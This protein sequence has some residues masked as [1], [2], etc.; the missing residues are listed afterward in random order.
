MDSIKGKIVLKNKIISGNLIFNKKIIEVSDVKNFNNDNYIIPGYIDLH[1]HGGRGYDTMDGLQ[2]ISKLSR[3]HL[4]NGTTTIFPTTVTASLNDTFNAM[5]GLNKFIKKNK[6]KIN[7]EGV[8]LEGPF[9]NPNKLGAQPPFAQSPNLDFINEI[10]KEAPIKIMTIA[11]EILGGLDFIDT[12]IQYGIKPQL[13]HSLASMD[14]CNLS[15]DRGVESFTH[16]YNAMSGFDH[17]NPG[18][19]ASAFSN[20]NYSEIICDLVHVHS[21]MIKLAFKNI[22]NMY[23]ITDCISASGMK[24]G[25]YNLGINKVYK[26]GNVVKLN[27][28][29]L[30][31]S[32]L[33][34]H[35]AFKN[36]IKIGF[37]ILEAVKLTS[38]NAA[39]YL[40]RSD[41]GSLKVGNRANFL[42]LDKGLELSSVY[43]NGN[44]VY[45]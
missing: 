7:I 8:H 5:K 32:V 6:L 29:T 19:V 3:Y 24:D 41:I 18:A 34:M 26:E 38:S 43:L 17:R 21:D 36:L 33:T 9:I 14:L 28:N 10:Q 15:I 44:K 16:L 25:E 1:C 13:G 30:G 35:Q 12:L 2:S 42:I 20:L 37:S 40:N 22:K 11:P 45:G 23:V 39:K 31:G 4:E 27:D